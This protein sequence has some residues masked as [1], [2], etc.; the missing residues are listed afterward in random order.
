MQYI[1]LLAAYRDQEQ[2]QHIK[3][4]IRFCESLMMLAHGIKMIV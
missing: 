4:R 3:S 1:A 2:D